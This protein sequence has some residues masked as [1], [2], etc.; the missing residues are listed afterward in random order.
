MNI[1]NNIA[2]WCYVKRQARKQCLQE[3]SEFVKEVE[4]LFYQKAADFGL[5]TVVDKEEPVG[6]SII[7]PRQNGLQFEINLKTFLGAL[8]PAIPDSVCTEQALFL[9]AAK[10]MAGKN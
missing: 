5:R 8:Y 6:V 7:L 10:T 3:Q 2:R 4:A 1:L 9:R